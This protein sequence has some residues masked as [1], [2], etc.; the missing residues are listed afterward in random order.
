MAQRQYQQQQAQQ[1]PP[2]Q[3]NHKRPVFEAKYGLCRAS[4]WANETQGGGVRYNVSFQRSYKDDQGNW[5]TTQSLNREDIG[6]MIMCL[7]DCQRFVYTKR[8]PG[9]E[10]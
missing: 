7:E 10:G 8:E 5:Q 4:V 6:L 9:Q 1:Q 3:N 2:P